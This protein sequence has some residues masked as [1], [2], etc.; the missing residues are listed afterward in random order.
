VTASSDIELIEQAKAGSRQALEEVVK[1]VQDRVYG[2][3]LRM[4]HSPSKAEDA[5]QEILIKVITSLDSFRGEGKFINWVL[6]ISSNHIISFK[7]SQAERNEITLAD[8]QRHMDLNYAK[9]WN[10]SDSAGYQA[11]VVEEARISCLHALLLTLSRIQRLA[12]ILGVVFGVSSGEGAYILDTTPENFRKRLSRARH[13]IKEFMS[14]NCALINSSNRCHCVRSIAWRREAGFMYK[15]GPVFATHPNH[16]LE[17]PAL[18]GYFEELDEMRRVSA[19]F[20]AT[21]R[22]AAP[23]DFKDMVRQMIDSG[24]FKVLA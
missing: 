10:E 19:L 6:R 7:R 8:A 22:Y 3:A 14:A 2:L 16:G 18:D 24:S 1:S 21:P 11:L 9:G 15:S 5:T 23:L 20:Q 13:R 12:F 17:G 4:L